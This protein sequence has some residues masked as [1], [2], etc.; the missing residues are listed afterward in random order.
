MDAEKERILGLATQH[1]CPN[2]VQMLQALGV[3][4][5]IGRREGIASGIW[6]VTPCSTTT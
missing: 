6:M 4:L 1:V 2:R 5:V 3:D